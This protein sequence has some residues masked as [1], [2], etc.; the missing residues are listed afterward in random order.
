MASASRLP[1][2]LQMTEQDAS[3][4]LSAQCHIGGKAVDKNMTGYVWKRRADGINI[5]N[6]SG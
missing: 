4:L 3:M 5:L 1:A 2:A 6:V